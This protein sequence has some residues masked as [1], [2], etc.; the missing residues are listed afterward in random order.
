MKPIQYFSDEYLSQARKSSP[1]QIVKFLDDYRR[2]HSSSELRFDQ[3]PTKMISI[4]LP[5]KLL[6]A[7]KTRAKKEQIPYQTL[8]KKILE[9]A[10]I[11]SN[12]ERAV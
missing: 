3:G 12:E 7:L 4:R 1:T 11:L 8:I 10:Q 5:F 2:L 6:A 9:D